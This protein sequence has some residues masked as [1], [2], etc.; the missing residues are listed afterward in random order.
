MNIKGQLKSIDVKVSKLAGGLGVSRP[1]LDSYIDLYERGE[2]IPNA[3][4]QEVFSYLFDKENAS[5]IEFAQKY[6][7]VKR[8]MLHELKGEAEEDA[9]IKRRGFLSNAIANMANDSNTPIENLEFVHLFLRSADK[10]VVKLLCE[11]FCLTNGFVDWSGK[12]MSVEE[13]RFFSSLSLFFKRYKEGSLEADEGELQELLAR[14]SQINGHR[15]P[16]A[17]DQ[18]IISYLSERGVD[19][20]SIDVEYLRRMLSES[21]EEK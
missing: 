11:Y 5:A 15:K 1:T 8:T 18:K 2:K 12:T 21:K 4:Y 14:N 3:K 7:Y 6:D 10:P 16:C 13:K 19:P 20:S 17:E 9:Q